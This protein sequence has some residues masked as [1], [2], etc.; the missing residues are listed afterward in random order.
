MMLRVV[1]HP[2]AEG[3]GG[4]GQAGTVTGKSKSAAA[5]ASVN[6]AGNHALIWALKHNSILRGR[7]GNKI[8]GVFLERVKPTQ[9]RANSSSRLWGAVYSYT[10]IPIT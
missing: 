6:R 5:A 4:W 3:S 1:P 10:C 9:I 2:A 8:Y 7:P